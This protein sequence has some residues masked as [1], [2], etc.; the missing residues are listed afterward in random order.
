MHGSVVDIYCPTQ[1]TP[2]DILSIYRMSDS[3]ELVS[4]L[5]VTSSNVNQNVP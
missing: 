2:P 1:R 4:D 3:S 5:N